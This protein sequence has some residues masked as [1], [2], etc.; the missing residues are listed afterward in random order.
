MY[1]AS[2]QK[3][4]NYY[5]LNYLMMSLPLHKYVVVALLLNCTNIQSITKY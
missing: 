3:S 5:F 2:V 1:T 4:A